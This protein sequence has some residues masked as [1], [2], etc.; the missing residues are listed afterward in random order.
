MNQP[1]TSFIRTFELLSRGLAL[2]V[3]LC[4]GLVLAGYLA[5][6]GAIVDLSPTLPG[7]SPLTALALLLLGAAALGDGNAR[8]REVKALASL[9][10]GIAV[11]TLL[12]EILFGEDKLSPLIA[13]RVFMFNAQRA[14][15]TSP[16][17]ALCL[18]ALGIATLARD[19]ARL[20]DPMSAFALVVAGFAL[21][22]YA[23]GVDDL[24]AVPLF[25]TVALHTALAI[26]ALAIASLTIRPRTGLAAIVTSPRAGGA[27]ARGLLA[28]TLLPPFA[29]WALLR[30]TDAHRLGPGAAMACLVVLT[31]VPLWLLILWTGKAASTLEEVRRDRTELQRAKDPRAAAHRRCAAR[32]DRLHRQD[33][34]LQVRQQDLSGLVLSRSG[35]GHRPQGLRPFRR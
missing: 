13:S 2:L 15:L 4:A 3:C 34:D 22:G 1:G 25:R 9:A 31:V 14:G 17:T 33:A 21:L 10:I 24:F 30:V 6:V 8:W 29:G 16:A 20:R 35:A 18:V 26:V 19:R 12:T 11:V 28:F 5:H 27:L 23:Y 32:A 7:M